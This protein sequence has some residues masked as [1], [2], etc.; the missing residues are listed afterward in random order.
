MEGFDGVRIEWAYQVKEISLCIALRSNSNL[1]LCEL[2]KY[3]ESPKRTK[4]M[5]SILHNVR[6][7]GRKELRCMMHAYQFQRAEMG[8]FLTIN[9]SLH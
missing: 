4:T 9:A 7:L 2:L 1:S 5:E 6:V 8:I 3:R